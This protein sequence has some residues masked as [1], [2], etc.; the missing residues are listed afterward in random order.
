MR[1]FAD[2]VPPSHLTLP[3]KEYGFTPMSYATI[4]NEKHGVQISKMLILR[5]APVPTH[6]QIIKMLILR[7]A[8]LPHY[9]AVHSQ[10]VSWVSVELAP[11]PRDTFFNL[12]LGCGV[13]GSRDRDRDLPQARRSQ[14]H[15]LRGFVNT[16]ARI[17]IVQY[18][19]VRVGEEAGRLRRAAAT[20][21]PQRTP[22][23]APALASAP[24]LAPASA[25]FP[26]LFPAPAPAPAT[27]LS[28]L[29]SPIVLVMTTLFL[30]SWLGI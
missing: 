2:M 11:T 21:T 26:A 12:V 28:V 14:L 23:P 3:E 6:A 1:D 29:T 4:C 30:G 5:G 25:L 13:H 8:P 17:N 20:L 10:L 16:Q 22:A 15:K 18:L 7:G 24:A 9:Y 19:G 27:Q